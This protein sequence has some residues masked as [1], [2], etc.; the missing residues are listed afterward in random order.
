MNSSFRR[1]GTRLAPVALLV[2]LCA[3]QIPGA[4]AAAEPAAADQ[5]AAR[6]ITGKVVRPAGPEWLDH[7]VFY[8]IYPQTFYDSNGDGIGDL[9]GIIAKLDYVKSLGVGA[10]WL[11]PFHDSP[12]R[13]AGYDASDFYTVAPRYGSNEDARRL[14]AAAHE[15]GLRVIIDYVASYTSIDHPWFKASCDPRPNK[16]SNWY[17]W[18]D[19]IWYPGWDKNRGFVQGYCERDGQYLS[20]LLLVPA[21]PQLRLREPRS[22]A[23]VA[24]AHGSPGRDGAQE[25]DEE[26]PALLARSRR[27]RLPRRHGRLARQERRSA[28]SPRSSGASCAS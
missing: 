13:D 12:F 18:T 23:A 10:I 22:G 15:R 14:F 26:R 8:Q 16:Y 11:N 1:H 3:L 2:S 21:G 25:G 28:A 27:G 9:P 17:V 24:A 6:P 4:F 5:S 7:A 20:Q 19:G